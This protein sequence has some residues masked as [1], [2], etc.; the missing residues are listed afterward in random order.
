VWQHA[1]THVHHCKPGDR[2]VASECV[3]LLPGESPVTGACENY[4][5]FINFTT[6]SGQ[7]R[8]V[9][10]KP[11][12]ACPDVS[13]ERIMISEETRQVTAFPHIPTRQSAT[14]NEANLSHH[15]QWKRFG[16]ER[17]YSSY[18][19]S[20]SALDGGEWLVSR[21]G[22]ALA[23]G[24]GPRYP[25]YMRL[26]GPQSRSGHKIL[27]EKFCSL[28]RGSNLYHSWRKFKLR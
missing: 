28:C 19:F 4:N 12:P 25:L 11:K 7:N 9:W 10:N 14:T 6:P 24:K 20:T 8:R 27:E 17:R 18:S 13:T 26:G 22:R 21:P 2:P 1:L 16:G 23:P 15:T 5:A 3:Q